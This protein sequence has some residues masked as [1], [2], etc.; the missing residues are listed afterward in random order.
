MKAAESMTEL[1]CLAKIFTYTT[2][3][4]YTTPLNETNLNLKTSSLEDSNFVEV[5]LTIDNTEEKSKKEK[6]CIASKLHKPF[7]HPKSARLIGLIKTARISDKDLLDMFKDLD[8]SC[9]ICMRYK[10]PSSR[11]VLGFSLAHDFNE[12]VAMDLK[13]FRGVYI[14][15][16]V[17]HATR[18][19]AV[20]LISTKQKEVIIDKILK[21]WIGIFGTPNL[22]LSN[23]GGEFNNELFREMGEQ[24]N[25]NFKTTAAESPWFNGIAKKQ[26]DAIGN[27]MEKVMSDVGCSLEVAL[28]WCISA[29]NSLLNSY[30]YITN[31]L[32]FA[33]NPNFSSVMQ[34]KPPAFEGII[35]SKLV[36]KICENIA[37]IRQKV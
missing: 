27:M 5:L 32:V 18:Y 10:R 17:D 12:T 6:K 36:G 34:N 8:K 13:Q 35:A 20:A 30:G 3:E 19:S 37:R 28:A 25:I 9:E 31:Q 11:P 24:L 22:F 23:N 15:H 2:S 21:H 7:G 4:H 14:L 26:N 16:M 29:K 33:Y 1:I